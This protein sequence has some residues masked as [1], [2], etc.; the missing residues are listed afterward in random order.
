MTSPPGPKLE[1][2]RSRLFKSLRIGPKSPRGPSVE[3]VGVQCPGGDMGTLYSAEK[4]ADRVDY[5]VQKNEQGLAMIK[6]L[7]G[8]D[9][10]ATGVEFIGRIVFS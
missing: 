7:Q 2:R 3:H 1:T 10:W 4:Q 8:T 5:L 6:A 9:V